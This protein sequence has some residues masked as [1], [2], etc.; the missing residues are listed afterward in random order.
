MAGRRVRMTFDRALVTQPVIY[1]LGREFPLVTN[2]RRA[3][4]DHGQ[5][6]VVLELTG[7]EDD[8]ERGLAWVQAQGVVV[9]PVEGDLVDK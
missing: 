1:R 5:G 9:E 4:I 6:W 2:I 7:E 3:D 8:L